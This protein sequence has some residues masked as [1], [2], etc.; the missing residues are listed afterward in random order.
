LETNHQYEANQ[1]YGKAKHVLS[2][3]SS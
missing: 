1:S 2:F 3:P